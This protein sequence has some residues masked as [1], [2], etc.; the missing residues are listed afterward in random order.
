MS[1][2]ANSFRQW[3][4]GRK[5]AVIAGAILLLGALVFGG[6]SF[7]NRNSGAEHS[8]R[9]LW[10]IL[11]KQARTKKFKPNLDL[12]EVTLV[13]PMTRTITMVTNKTTGAVRTITRVSKP[14][15]GKAAAT[16]MPETT[17]STYFLTNQMQSQTYE[18]MYRFIGE[19]L[20]VAEHLLGDTNI[21]RQVAGM[22]MAIEA[23]HYARTNAVNPWL[24]ARIC[25]AYLWPNL[26]LVENTNRTLLMP[27]AVLGACD[28]AFN[29]AGETNNI[30][31]NYELMI[32]K[33]SR[34]AAYV[35][36]LRYRLA[37]VYQNLGEDEKALP[38]LKQIK[39]YRMNRVPG[40]IA[41]IEERL[42]KK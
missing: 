33:V 31:R 32:A 9:A 38:L 37:Q 36:L 14:T 6:W 30:I 12:S 7:F 41:A 2:A 18:E 23:S 26:S 35:D 4:S 40:E 17:L 16:T 13:A 39:N 15:S 21:Q 19:E 24:A 25:E 20:Y 1:A 5:T 42:G 3:S 22:A 29:D 10:K 28:S 11:A 34:S 8:E 27:D